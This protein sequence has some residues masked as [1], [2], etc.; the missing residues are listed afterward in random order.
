V[1]CGI[2]VTGGAVRLT[3]S[4]LGCPT[5]PDCTS[6]KVSPISH[7]ANGYHSW[8]EFGNRLLTFLLVVFAIA[9]IVIAVAPVSK[10]LFPKNL[11]TIRLLALSQILGI[12]G[13]AIVGGISVLTKLNPAVVG[14]HFMISIPIVAAAFSLQRL[15]QQKPEANL[16]TNQKLIDILIRGLVFVTA[17]VILVG[18][19]VTGSGPHSGDAKAK[20][21]PF[22]ARDVAWLHADL[23]IALISLS[24]GLLLIVMIVK[25]TSN[26]KH[27]QIL[28][29]RFI[30]ISLGQGLIGY[31]QF[32]T[33]LP[34]ILVGAHILGAALVW[35]AVWD[36]AVTTGVFKKKVEKF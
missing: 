21:Y 4:G 6:G 10:K 8:V 29:Y 27:L 1:E 18:T 32:F 30:G 11:K 22:I 23:V 31:I 13:Q 16:E 28:T 33:H 7:P 34:I 2:I 3:G 35:V 25:P 5:W 36:I 14:L 15:G 17:A 19:V 20:R 24:I 26:P 9:S 12:V